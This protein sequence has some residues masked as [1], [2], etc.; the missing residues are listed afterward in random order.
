MDNN[1]KLIYE[2]LTYQVN[3]I[4][5]EA[6]NELGQFANEKQYA[7]FIENK[8][9]NSNL[10]FER[11]K[12]LPPS[13]KGETKGRHRV[14]FLVKNKLLLELKTKHFLDKNDYYQTQRYLK[15]LNLKLGILV[16][17]R[18]KRLIPKRIINSSAKE[19]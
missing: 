19:I 14:D 11:E 10:D 17:F 1:S 7:D 2:D 6:H 8:L 4:L 16:N 3:G 5:F 12:I 9:K 18:Q 15:A 13:F